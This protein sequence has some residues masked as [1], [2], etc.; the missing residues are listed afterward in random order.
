MVR[1]RKS[2]EEKIIPGIL[3]NDSEIIERIYKDDFERVKNM[4]RG[5]G[6]IGL[7]PWDIFQE[8]LTRAIVNVRQGKFKGESAF[9]TYLYGICRNLCLK[10][11]RNRK[12]VTKNEWDEIKQEEAEEDYFDEL[13]KMIQI[14]KQ[15]DEQC[16]KIIDLR[17]GLQKT[18]AD[19]TRFEAIATTLGISADNARQR[20]RRCFAKLKTAVLKQLESF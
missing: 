3:Q 17:F 7:E 13:Q 5:F 14:K 11:Y 18:E 4:V 12:T 20:F 8:G 9:S 19:S 6:T 1:I 10:A 2:N 16:R 15:L